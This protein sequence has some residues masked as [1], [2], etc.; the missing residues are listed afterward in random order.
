VKVDTLPVLVGD[1][2]WDKSQGIQALIPDPTWFSDDMSTALI[3]RDTKESLSG[4]W[5]IELSEFPHIRREIDKVKSFF[6]RQTDRFRRA[7]DRANRDWPRQ[8]V[9]IATT[10]ELE[11]ID[12][13]GNRR[14]WPVPMSGPADVKAI[15]RER[16]QLWAEALHWYRAGYQWWLTRSLE[17]IA[18][19]LQEEYLEPD[20]WD[21][22]IANWIE[23]RAPRDPQ[24]EKVLP[25]TTQ[26][27]L[28]GIGY[29]MS[30]DEEDRQVIATKADQMRAASCLKR[31]GC[32]REP[33]ARRVQGR[34]ERRWVANS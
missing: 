15:E 19:Q 31:L 14:F 12:T 2:G 30:P 22:L 4:K 13:T 9:F 5:L 8:C 24:T 16:D 34:R 6:S 23:N 7:Y 17:A 3:D 11:F 33:H 20:A 26:Q 27:V 28:W 29:A 1:Q 21:E 25:F 10:N 18:A 32:R